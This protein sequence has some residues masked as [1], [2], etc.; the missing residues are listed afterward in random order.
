MRFTEVWQ[1]WRSVLGAAARNTLSHARQKIVLGLSL[2]L[3]AFAFQYFLNLRTWSD[4]QKVIVSLLGAAFLVMLGSFLKHVLLEPAAIHREQRQRVADLEGQLA[5]E[6]RGKNASP[7]AEEVTPGLEF[8][9]WTGAQSR[10]IPRF[11]VG[12]PSVV[13]VTNTGLAIPTVARGVIAEIQFSNAA[14]TQQLTVP[15]SAWYVVTLLG[16]TTIT[17]GWRPSADLDAGD[18]QPFVLFVSGDDG[19]VWVYKESGPPLGILEDGQWEALIRVTSANITG[20]EGVLRFTLNRYAGLQ[21]QNPAFT[22]G[23]RLPPRF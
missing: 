22:L 19:K 1:Y 7:E 6:E 8:V 17:E 23:R 9:Q 3:I 11:G 18:T 21:H 10:G 12:I 16:T 14:G 20:F 13:E 5:P 2:S 15:S 4:T